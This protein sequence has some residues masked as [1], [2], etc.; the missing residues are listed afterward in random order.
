MTAAGEK[1]PKSGGTW[2][3]EQYVKKDIE[4][5]AEIKPEMNFEEI[6]LRIRATSMPEDGI[7]CYTVIK[8]KFFY[9]R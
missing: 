8:D 4:L 5:L 9:L 6:E 1:L 2:D 7:T 3:A